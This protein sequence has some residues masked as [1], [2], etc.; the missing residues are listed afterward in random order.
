MLI[1]LGLNLNY[2]YEMEKCH[3]TQDEDDSRNP[4]MPLSDSVA[5]TT[6]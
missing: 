2:L 6:A 1:C 4:P 5:Q 3:K